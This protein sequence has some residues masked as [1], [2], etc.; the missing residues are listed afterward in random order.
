MGCVLRVC[1]GYALCVLALWCIVVYVLCVVLVLVLVLVLVCNVW[2]VVSV[3]CGV[4]CVVSVVCGVC[5]VWCVCGVCV[6]RL[7]TLRKKKTVCRFKT[8]PC[9]GSK[10]L[11][12]YRQN[13]KHVLPHAGV[14]PAHTE[15]F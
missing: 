15:A 4:W 5:G 3:V 14:L 2:C 1:V 12:V 8:S 9:E 13:A 7:G 11:R 6:A 10:R